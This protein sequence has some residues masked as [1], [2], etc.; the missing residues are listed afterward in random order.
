M[1]AVEGEALVVRGKNCEVLAA[2]AAAMDHITSSEKKCTCKDNYWL[3][4]QICR[5]CPINAP[6]KAGEAKHMRAEDASH[7]AHE[8][9][10]RLI[11]WTDGRPATLLTLKNIQDR[12]DAEKRL[13]NLAYHDQLTGAPN[14]QRLRE[15]F[16]AIA[17]R[18]EDEAM[19]GMLAIFDLDNFKTVN[20]TYGHNTG[21]IMLRRIVDYLES[22]PELEGRIYRLG[23]DEFI[24]LYCHEEKG[25][26]LHDI[27]A[28]YE[29]LLQKALRSYTLPNIE[30]SCTL[31]MGAALFPRHGANFSELLRKTDIALYKAKEN[32]R[33]QYVFFEDK[34]D[35][36]KKFRDLY[37]SIQPVLLGEGKIYGYELIDKGDDLQNDGV[38]YLPESNRALDMLG[39]ESLQSED[40]YFIAYT[41]QMLD[42][43]AGHNLMRE[44]FIVTINLPAQVKPSDLGLYRRLRK[45]GYQ[46][47]MF[48]LRESNA[49]DAIFGISNLFRFDT[50]GITAAGQN[51]IVHLHPEKTF[52]AQGVN[53]RRD[54]EIAARRGFKLF[55]GFYFEDN[56]P[57]TH[58]TKELEPMRFNYLRLLQ[59]TSTDDYVNFRDISAVIASDVVLSYKLLK[60]L[61]SAAVGLRNR[62]SS[63]DMAVSYLGENNLK[64]WVAML[65]MRGIAEDKPLELMR[66]S[67]IRARF[68][69]LLAPLLRPRR[70]DKHVFLTGMFS[71][72]HIALEK[73]KEELLEEIPM[74]DDI[75]ESLLTRNGIYSDLLA[76]FAHYEY[77]N[78]DEVARFSDLNRLDAQT[79][80][81]CYIDAVKWYNSLAEQT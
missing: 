78:W 47:A 71:L 35:S 79:V 2:S 36:A 68:G 51:R 63:I 69:E 80:N 28:L 16:D 7:N 53:T 6:G 81:Q 32:G 55:Q 24:L 22:V 58:K 39:L 15:D 61:N 10:A 77:A 41:P 66:V 49:D 50:N 56:P 14:R 27:Q 46:L 48:G 13:Y 23:G 1:E 44:K 43:D 52:I 64:K 37:V 40:K 9:T 75:R 34:Y 21:D 33:N 3:Y 76:F 57:V 73:T 54:Y 62:I 11:Q 31:S 70:D 60:L 5:Q 29:G 25:E 12:L 18:V 65:A 74:A 26:P 72:L 67:L 30:T 17:E 45:A 19:R 4:P 59:L 38:L 42:T 8:V 20:D